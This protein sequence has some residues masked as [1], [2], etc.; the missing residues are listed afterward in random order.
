MRASDPVS[1]R[2]GRYG[3]DLKHWVRHLIDPHPS[4]LCFASLA[5]CVRSVKFHPGWP[6][7][8]L[9]TNHTFV[10]R[11]CFRGG[12]RLLAF[13][14]R[15][16]VQFGLNGHPFEA[17][18]GPSPLALSLMPIFGAH[19]MSSPGHERF[20]CFSQPLGVLPRFPCA[21]LV[22]TIPLNLNS[23]HFAVHSLLQ[24]SKC[25]VTLWCCVVRSAA[26]LTG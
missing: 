26:T 18:A 13:A 17:L 23:R 9:L 24:L 15:Y 8:P 22:S 6:L 14:A 4:E 10:V 11:C 5:K 19:R 20:S 3:G 25:P 21:F 1:I 2:I 7:I 12:L 16:F